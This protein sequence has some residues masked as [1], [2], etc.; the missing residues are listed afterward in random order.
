MKNYIKGFALA[1][2]FGASQLGAQSNPTPFNLNASGNYSFTSWASS[3]PSGSYPSNMIFHLMNTT[4]PPVTASAQSNL[5]AGYSYAYTSGTRVQGLGSNGVQFQ[6]AT[7]PTNVG[8]TANR[9]GE[10]VLGLVTSSRT[11]IQLS[12]KA[13]TRTTAGNVMAI[14]CQYRVGNSGA[15]SDFSPISEYVSSSTLNDSAVM[16]VTLP[17]SLE[18][19]PLVQIRWIYYRVSGASSSS[20]TIRLDDI[21]VT[22]LPAVTFNPL[23]DVCINSA[24]FQIT[25]GSP[26]GGVYSGTGVVNGNMFDP[27]VSGAGTFQ[28]TYT[29]TDANGISNSASINIVVSAGACIIPVGLAQGSCGATGLM[30]NSYIY[31]E[32]APGAQNYEYEFSGGNLSAPIY[33]QR[34]NWFTDFNL[35]WIPQ[36]TYGETYN[37]RVRA[38][39]AN[40]W[41]SFANTCTITLAPTPPVPQLTAASCGQSNLSLSSYIYTTNIAGAQDYEYQFTDVS[42]G[43]I[44][45]RTRGNWY[46]NFNLSWPGTLQ[47]GATYNVSVRA[48]LAGV[49]GAYGEPCQISIQA[50]PTT[51][52]T[53]SSC[54]A[55]DLLPT[56]RI[57]ADA[58]S[59]ATNYRYRFTPLP[60]G[61]PIVRARNA[62]T[63]DFTL[64]YATGLMPSTTYMVEVQ[65]YAGGVWGPY[66]SACQIST[67]ASYNAARF[68]QNETDETAEVAAATV[69]AYPNPVTD[70]QL[71]LSITGMQDETVTTIEMYDMTGRLVITQQVMITPGANVVTINM[72]GLESGMYI[73]RIL[74][75]AGVIEQQNIMKQ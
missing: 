75:A 39:V 26:S 34:G 59:G 5:L 51:Q 8:Y 43:Q 20:R 10:T 37:V 45:T 36:I 7:T 15:Y 30:K 11:N 33:Y 50:F 24:P 53:L 61:T 4:N 42:T 73:V 54:G 46:T 32:S 25:D 60:S 17:V 72:E 41:G 22:S 3:S 65:A 62:S 58:V 66:G 44:I 9:L 31:T 28:L 68:A 12:W 64:Q 69:V 74:S 57:Y 49:W 35:Q 19:Q 29:Y 2:L 21:S 38:R 56:D 13:Q 1:M 14:R 6:N 63:T 71:N 27:S 47:Y 16:N 18:D 67:S 23:P 70:G 48:K 52:L 55:V 40:T